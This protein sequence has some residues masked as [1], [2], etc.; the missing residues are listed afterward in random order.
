MFSRRLV[1][2]KIRATRGFTDSRTKHARGSD[3][4]RIKQKRR[5]ARPRGLRTSMGGA[6]HALGECHR[7]RR[8]GRQ[9][10]ADLPRVPELWREDPTARSPELAKGICYWRLAGWCTP[11][12]PH[13]HVDLH[14]HGPVLFGVSDLLGQLPPGSLHAARRGRSL[15][16][17][18]P[19]FLVRSEAAHQGSLQPTA[20]TRLYVSHLAWCIDRVHRVRHLETDSVLLGRPADGRVSSCTCLALRQHVGD[21]AFRARPS[22]HGCFAWVEQ[23]CLDADRMESRPGVSAPIAPVVPKDMQWLP[24]PKE[25]AS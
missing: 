23:F 9:R 12:A 22:C 15:A 8:D 25:R 5:G 1:T 20:E 6:I 2:G 10:P 17:S 19:L 4:N 13:L 24:L 11:V 16:H 21:S 18:A 3:R 14:R 7:S